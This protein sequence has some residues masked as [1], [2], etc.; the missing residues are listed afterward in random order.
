MQT[1]RCY[2]IPDLMRDA[3][4]R[5]VDP[6]TG[7]LTESGVAEIRSLTAAAQH[8]TADLACYIRE[9]EAES[10]AIKA[11]ISA[12]QERADRLARRAERWRSYL[13]ET[14]EVIGATEVKDARISVA[15]KLNPPAV[16]ISADAEIPTLY[17]RIVP[18]KIEPDKTAIK[19]ALKAGIEIEGASLVI[20]RRLVLA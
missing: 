18:E 20:K 9:L 3:F 6:E 14:L 2:E 12:S 5:A 4:D 15:V 11:V 8:S 16:V 19:A 13:L 1:L 10:S 17:C 7:E